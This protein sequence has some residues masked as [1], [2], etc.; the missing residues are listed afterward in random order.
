MNTQ[1]N[2]VQK[3][4]T[5]VSKVELEEG[6]QLQW[7]IE[8]FDV[9][10]RMS[11]LNLSQRFGPFNEGIIIKLSIVKEADQ[12]VLHV[13]IEPMTHVVWINL[14]F[15]LP[16]NKPT[17]FVVG[18]DPRAQPISIFK[19]PFNLPNG[20]KDFKLS[21]V[22]EVLVVRTE[23]VE[24]EQQ[25]PLIDL[26]S[27]TPPVNSHPSTNPFSFPQPNAQPRSTSAT[28]PLPETFHELMTRVVGPSLHTAANCAVEI[29]RNYSAYHTIQTLSSPEQ[30][31]ES[32][33]N[34]REQFNR[35]MAN[36][37]THVGHAAEMVETAARHVAASTG[38]TNAERLR[39]VINSLIE[40]YQSQPPAP[41]PPVPPRH[42]THH[43]A[44]APQPNV[45]PEVQ[46]PTQNAELTPTV[47]EVLVDVSE[48]PMETEN[49]SSFEDL[50]QPQQP[51]PSAP[52]ATN[53]V[54]PVEALRSMFVNLKQRRA[55]RSTSQETDWSFVFKS[56]GLTG[57]LRH[58]KHNRNHHSAGRRITAEHEWRLPDGKVLHVEL[59]YALHEEA[60]FIC[61]FKED[62]PTE[63]AFI[64][65]LVDANGTEIHRIDS[66][67]DSFRGFT[68][69]QLL[70]SAA[71]DS[72]VRVRI[73]A[74]PSMD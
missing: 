43:E 13:R 15:E 29:L 27:Q 20:L 59:A 11:N 37:N 54:Y 38:E 40:H 47:D 62:P 56:K 2:G 72:C 52:T 39:D 35:L 23:I 49:S 9:L 45:E 53:T 68:V 25:E 44:S 18:G 41:R 51:E 22:P 7:T 70:Q 48:Q 4:K 14:Q 67:S 66:F 58:I 73:D 63:M 65:T 5:T 34:C 74:I 21:F 32:L 8:N 64:Q 50:A 12:L 71:I 30:T 26:D 16:G 42:N 61:T 28:A 17:K 3:V 24:G 57:L 31:R 1:T 36:A 10:S 69:D 60:P 33:A 6:K 46:A 19:Q 55:S